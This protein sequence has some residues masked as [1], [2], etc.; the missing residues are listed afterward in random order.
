MAAVEASVSFRTWALNLP[1]SVSNRCFHDW[2]L[3]SSTTGG[4]AGGGVGSTTEGVASGATGSGAGAGGS[5]VG[6]MKRVMQELKNG[7]PVILFPEGTRSPDGE[8]RKPKAGVGLIACRTSVPVLPARIF[9]SFEAFG[10]GGS[11]KRP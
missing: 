2:L 9:G 11:L 1:W 6:A 5:D 4:S 7:K 10:K 8:P 3:G